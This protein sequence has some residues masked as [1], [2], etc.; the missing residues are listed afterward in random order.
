MG[1]QPSYLDYIQECVNATIGDLAGKYM[2]ELGDQAIKNEGIPEL[3]GKKYYQN[4]GVLHT[5]FDLNGREGA[6][7]VDLSEPICNEEWLNAFDIVTNAGTTEHVE[8]FESQYV[9]FLNVHNCLKQGGVAIHILPDAVEL[10][11]RGAWRD[12]CNYYFTHDFF[13]LLAELNGYTL[14]S[15]KVINGSRCVCLQKNSDTPFTA[16]KETLLAAIVRNEEC[17][18]T[19]Y[20]GINDNPRFRPL[21]RM[22][23]SFRDIGR[24]VRRYLSRRIRLFL[25]RMLT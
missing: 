22:Y 8:P 25:R 11:E 14:V 2:L 20:L 12:H 7:R 15:S 23:I 6:I 3:T 17:G 24:P 10:E 18:T 4:R 13:A 19:V 9:C 16:E 1:L 21:K 5:S